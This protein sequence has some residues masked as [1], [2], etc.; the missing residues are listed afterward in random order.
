[1]QTDLEFM[2]NCQ[3]LN[4]TI[5]DIHLSNLSMLD[6]IRFL[7]LGG[8]TKFFETLS[9]IENYTPQQKYYNQKTSDKNIYLV[10]AVLE[11]FDTFTKNNV[12]E[13]MILI[14]GKSS[15]SDKGAELFEGFKI[16]K[17]PYNDVYSFN[18]IYENGNIDMLD[19]SVEK[20]EVFTTVIKTKS[21]PTKGQLICMIL[22]PEL[23]EKD[24]FTNDFGKHSCFKTNFNPDDIYI[25]QK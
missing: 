2:Q 20:D 4:I 22:T 14:K 9:K 13:A 8:T 21:Y 19:N 7:K 3:D 6:R 18:I 23:I 24:T 25:Q 11:F 10:D 16:K 1:M 15:Y 5:K 17:E 12:K